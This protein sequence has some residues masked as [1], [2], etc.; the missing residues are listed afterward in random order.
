MH[1]ALGGVG[2]IGC[3]YYI[4]GL[5]EDGSAHDG[6]VGELRPYYA[7][8]GG[9][10]SILVAAIGGYGYGIVV[11]YAASH[12]PQIAAVGDGYQLGKAECLPLVGSW[13]VKG[14]FI[15]LRSRRIIVSCVNAY[16]IVPFVGIEQLYAFERLSC[17][18]IGCIYLDGEVVVHQIAFMGVAAI[19]DGVSY[20]GDD[21]R[22]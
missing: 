20:N 17:W 21:M 2:G 14:L 10:A 13:K 16:G 15:D 22:C 19:S 6:H 8:G 11:S 5:T 3:D 12:N 18:K 1:C 9:P 4:G 7:V